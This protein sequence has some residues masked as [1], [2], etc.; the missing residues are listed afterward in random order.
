MPRIDCSSGRNDDSR[1]K[2]ALL[3]IARVRFQAFETR[4]GRIPKLDEPIFFDEASD[5]PAKA[6]LHEARAQIER[7]AREA[8]VALEPVL[9]LLGLSRHIADDVKSG[10]RRASHES[11][12]KSRLRFPQSRAI[13][14][15]RSSTAGGWKRFLSDKRLHRRHRVTRQE[16]QTLSR[17]AFLG[18]TCTE[19]DFLLVLAAIRQHKCP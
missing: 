7:A 12:M 8:R 1:A 9:C 18:E 13:S 4:F 15:K 10:D 16:L 3:R 6:S 19:Q 11:L 5:H 17:T 14:R 2:Y